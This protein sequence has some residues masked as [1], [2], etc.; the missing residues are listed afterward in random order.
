MQEKNTYS[1]TH[2][3]IVMGSWP[4][5]MGSWPNS[6]G[7]CI[8]LGSCSTQGTHLGSSV[9]LL[10][11]TFAALMSQCTSCML[12]RCLMARATSSS[13][14]Y[15]AWQEGD[16]RCDHGVT[17]GVCVHVWLCEVHMEYT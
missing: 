10:S 6:H 7:L 14:R 15:S 12:C 1:W 2:G 11:S 9:L 13:V 8:Q 3:L 4:A 17:V 16:E 5:L